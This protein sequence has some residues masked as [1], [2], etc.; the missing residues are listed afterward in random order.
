MKRV[1][2]YADTKII[3]I[4]FKNNSLVFQF[5]KSKWHQNGKDHV[6]SW[7]IYTNPHGPHIFP[8]LELARYLFTHPELLVNKT[9]LFQGK[10]QY[11]WYSRMFIL[12]IKE[13]MEQLKTL[14]V[15]EGN[16]GTHSRRKG[17]TTM[18]DTGC[19]VS[20]PIASICIIAGWVM[21]RVKGKCLK[22]KYAGDQYV[23]R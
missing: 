15:E 3:H 17:V 7:H 11:N 23:G 16:I 19:T 12:L 13:N 9:S 5:A 8:V 14:G 22:R 1:K 4:T 18:F 20:P 21:G 6:G 10:S 2:N